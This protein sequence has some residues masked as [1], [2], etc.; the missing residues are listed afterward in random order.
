VLIDV[1][2]ILEVFL[3][4][5]TLDHCNPFLFL[6]WVVSGLPRLH[7]LIMTMLVEIIPILSQIVKVLD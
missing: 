2:D 5:N 6:S 1:F 3:D 7:A 4:L